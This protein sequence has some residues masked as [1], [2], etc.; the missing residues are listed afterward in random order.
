MSRLEIRVVSKPWGQE[1]II[2]VN[3]SYVVK[4]LTMQAGQRCS[5]Q[6]HERKR[7]T[8]YVVSGL[9]KITTGTEL[10]LMTQKIY[11]ANSFITI[12]PKTIHR[13]EGIE[14]TVY[15]EAS[16]TELDDVVRLEDDY[17]RD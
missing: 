7:E 10:K 8:I 5:L 9:L 11:S 13:M 3:G 16:T 6:Y 14:E 15:L 17:Q 4:R 2:E 12:E 1:E